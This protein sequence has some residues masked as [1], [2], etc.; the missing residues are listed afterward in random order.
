MHLEEEQAD[1][2][3]SCATRPPDVAGRRC[4]LRLS[5]LHDGA[6]GVHLERIRIYRRHGT[7]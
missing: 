2:E 5:E 4:H 6:T 3:P 1:R 7:R